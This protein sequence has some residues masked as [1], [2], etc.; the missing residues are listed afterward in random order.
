ME[1]AGSL[2]P[3]LVPPRNSGMADTLDEARAALANRYQAL[4]GGQKAGEVRGRNAAGFPAMSR[5]HASLP[6]NAALS[7][8]LRLWAALRPIFK[9]P[10]GLARHAGR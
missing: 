4:R 1:L 7:R 8:G 10:C 9:S 5:Y 6:S 3:M 2:Q